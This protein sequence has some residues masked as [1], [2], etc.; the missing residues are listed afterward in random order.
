[1]T[2]PDNEHTV[3]R[4]TAP[5][6]DGEGLVTRRV[7]VARS[8]VAWVRYVFE[9]NEGL[10]NLHVERDGVLTL[11]A[12]ECRAAELDAVLRELGE[13]IELTPR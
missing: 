10:A 6:F 2:T 12:P 11:V 4:V 8:E 7:R 1:M 5:L 3:S 13:E 9:G